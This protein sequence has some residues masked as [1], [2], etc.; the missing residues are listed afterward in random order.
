MTFAPL[1]RRLAVLLLGC[2][3]G[4]QEHSRGD[5]HIFAGAS[6]TNIHDTLA[7]TVAAFYDT[8]SGYKF[9]MAFRSQGLNAGY[10]RGDVLTFTALPSTDLGT[11]QLLGRPL[12][13]SRLAVQIR[14][15]E[16]P[17]GG[18][19]GFWEGDGENPGN[20]ITFSVPV[21]T[22]DGLDSFLISENDGSPGSDAYGHI[23]GRAFTTTLPG[24][25]TIG[26]RLVDLST[27]G[28]GGG[29]LHRPS[30]V[31][32][33]F[34]QAG[35][36]I[37]SLQ[38]SASGT[39]I[40]LRSAPGVTN[41]IETCDSLSLLSWKPLPVTIRG[42]STLQSIADTNTDSEHRFYRLRV[43]HTPP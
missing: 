27:N 1:D 15:V 28:P 3:V 19:L 35:A 12:L 5:T 6:G 34:F 41:Q 23:H 9:P 33:M 14:S 2:L 20:K 31:F 37:E 39:R 30:P 4:G 40:F 10:H 8:Q 7:F 26:F 16:G 32:P 38:P 21:G 42:N 17:V 43:L 36:T 29:P 25:Y 24:L 18:S 13:G 22:A 11:G